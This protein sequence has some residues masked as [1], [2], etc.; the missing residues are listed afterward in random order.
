MLPFAISSFKIRYM[1]RDEL[2]TIT[3]DKWDS[4]VWGSPHTQIFILWGKSD[5]W[6]PDEYRDEL[7]KR[8]G[9]KFE[10]DEERWKPVMEID[11]TG[12]L[13]DF[14][15]RHGVKMAEK[16]VPWIRDIIQTDIQRNVLE[17]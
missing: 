8:R 7:I 17:N 11:E 13:H 5:G 9:R 3:H 10:A 14:C 6:I 12:L 15:I 2:H 1:A 4:E 16:V